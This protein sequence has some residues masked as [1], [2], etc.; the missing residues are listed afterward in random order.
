MLGILQSKDSN[1][2]WRDLESVALANAPKDLNK[3]AQKEWI[4]QDMINNVALAQEKGT[5]NFFVTPIQK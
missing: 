2:N 3:D 1:I 4:A 5:I